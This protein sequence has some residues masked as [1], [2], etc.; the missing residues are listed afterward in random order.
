MF[1]NVMISENYDTDYTKIMK[2]TSNVP[3]LMNSGFFGK[4]NDQ[5]VLD[6]YVTNNIPVFKDKKRK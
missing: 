1:R 3:F 6:G 4:L 2:A 5:Y